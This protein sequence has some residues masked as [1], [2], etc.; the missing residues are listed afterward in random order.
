MKEDFYPPAEQCFKVD[1]FVAPGRFIEAARN[2]DFGQAL[3][4]AK[5]CVRKGHRVQM[6]GQSGKVM[7]S[8]LWEAPLTEREKEMLSQTITRKIG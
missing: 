7:D 5:W 3:L 6:R 1:T 8:A 2:R 4:V